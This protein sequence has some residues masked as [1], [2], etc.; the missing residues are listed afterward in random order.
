MTR[1][2]HQFF[3]IIPESWKPLFPWN[4]LRSEIPLHHSLGSVSSTLWTF[5]LVCFLSLALKPVF[6]WPWNQCA[7]LVSQLCSSVCGTI[8]SGWWLFWGFPL[9]FYVLTIALLQSSPWS[10]S[11]ESQSFWTSTLGCPASTHVITLVH[12][13]FLSSSIRPGIHHTFPLSLYVLITQLVSLP[14]KFRFITKIYLLQTHISR[15]WSLQS[16]I[17]IFP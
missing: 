6:P 14:S 16:I 10:S 11:S 13:I 12:C 2:N 7:H 15:I 8:A 4:F 5:E 9:P 1:N 3:Y 17:I